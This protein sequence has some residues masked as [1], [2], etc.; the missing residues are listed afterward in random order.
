M[1][2]HQLFGVGGNALLFCTSTVPVLRAAHV[3]SIV[4]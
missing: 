2:R 3:P 1:E 4:S